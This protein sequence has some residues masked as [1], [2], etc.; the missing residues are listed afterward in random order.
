MGTTYYSDL[1]FTLFSALTC[2]RSTW[3]FPQ[4]SNSSRVPLP[5]DLDICYSPCLECSPP[6]LYS[7]LLL[8]FKFLG[9]I[10]SPQRGLHLLSHILALNC[11]DHLWLSQIILFGYLI[12]LCQQT[13]CFLQ[14]GMYCIFFNL[15][16]VLGGWLLIAVSAGL[17]CPP[18]SNW[19]H[20]S[21]DQRAGGK[22]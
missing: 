7:W 3:P 17:S 18:A 8:V 1:I 2:F 5:E 22:T 16:C 9:K 20:L 10:S 13:T 6:N 11:S 4:F 15:L 14:A 12:S 21:R 19:V